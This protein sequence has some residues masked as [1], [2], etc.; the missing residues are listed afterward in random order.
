MWVIRVNLLFHTTS[1]M[2]MCTFTRI[3]ADCSVYWKHWL[4]SPVP[5]FPPLA[6]I[7]ARKSFETLSF[8]WTLTKDTF[9]GSQL[10]FS[11]WQNARDK[12]Q[13]EKSCFLKVCWTISMH[14]FSYF[15][16]TIPMMCWAPVSLTKS[17]ISW[18]WN[19]CLTYL[20]THML[21]VLKTMPK[22]E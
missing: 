20:G 18:G 22:T 15:L 16:Q 2:C 9:L 10:C 3:Y 5:V 6:F 8:N 12:K 21:P 1:Y 13:L 11:L 14:L 17:W 19:P 7:L 4:F